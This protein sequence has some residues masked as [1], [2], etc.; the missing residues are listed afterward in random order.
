MGWQ[1]YGFI[2]ASA[3]A[4]ADGPVTGFNGPVTF[5]DKEDGRLNQAYGIL[6]RVAN[7]DG[8]GFDWGGRVDLLYGTDYV[9]TQAAGLELHQNY[10]AHWN[11]VGNE[12]GLALP[13]AYAEVAL[14]DLSVKVGHFYTIIGYQV[15]PAPGNFFIT[16]PYTFQYGEP[17]THAGALGTWSFSDSLTL[18]GAVVNGWDKVDADSDLAA[19]MGGF[20]WAPEDARFTLLLTGIIGEEDGAQLPLQGTRALYS[21]VLTVNVTDNFQYVLQHDNG[22]QENGVAAGVDAEWYGVNQYLFYTVNECWKLGVRGE[23]FRD[24]DGVRLSAAPVRLG[25]L[26]NLGVPG[27]PAAA[28]GNYYEVAAGVNWTPHANLVIRPEVRFDWSDGTAIAPYD[29]LQ[30]DS[31]LIAAVDAIVHF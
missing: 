23:W 3:T 1:L 8:Y 11:G 7:P 10:G 14:G 22:Q 18:Y 6:E 13:Q 21:L 15:V 4:N 25:G 5:L 27:L 12:Y 16:Q 2:N 24:D 29:D 30:K 19:A 20:L 17:F 26:A 28:A 31:Q 9:F